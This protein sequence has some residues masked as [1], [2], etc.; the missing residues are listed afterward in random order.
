MLECDKYISSLRLPAP[1]NLNT[2][3]CRS[4]LVNDIFLIL[5]KNLPKHKEVRKFVECWTRNPQVLIGVSN[6]LYFSGGIRAT[7]ILI[8]FIIYLLLANFSGHLLNRRFKFT[9]SDFDPYDL[10]LSD[11]NCAVHNNFYGPHKATIL[12]IQE[13]LA[14]YD[15]PVFPSSR[16]Y[17]V[18][19][20]IRRPVVDYQEFPPLREGQEKTL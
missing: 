7:Y 8:I 13:V 5:F 4:E 6:T 14:E 12:K 3:K 16:N 9:D 20:R 18:T 15:H 1:V 2:A 17:E 11:W 19:T 10:K